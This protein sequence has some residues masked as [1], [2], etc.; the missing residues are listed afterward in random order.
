MSIKEKLQLIVSGIKQNELQAFIS[1]AIIA[2]V[3]LPFL[4]NISYTLA[5]LPGLTNILSAYGINLGQISH[6]EIVNPFTLWRVVVIISGVEVFGYI[7][8]KTIGQKKGLL[9]TSIAGGFISSTST[10]QSLANQSKQSK[11][12]NQLTGAAIFANLSSFL[13][14]FILI[15]SVNTLFL[16][17]NTLYLFIISI[18][19]LIIG[20]YF[21]KS[22]SGSTIE[23]EKETQAILKEEKIFSLKPAL[24]FALIFLLVKIISKSALSLFGE[25]AFLV[26]ILLASLTGMDAITINLSQLAGETITFQIAVFAFIS[27]N[28]V[29]LISKAVYAFLQGKQEF[30]VKFTIAMF[31]IIGFGFLGIIPLL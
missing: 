21:F 17:K 24:Q 15:A 26:T 30:A 19:S 14:H 12:I 10:T 16:T 25:G 23:L 27:A 6:I 5:D 11:N 22:K 31:I 2:L 1:Y 29:N 13:Q 7:L 8:E 20:Y 3:I 18:I 4:P 9:L 28:G